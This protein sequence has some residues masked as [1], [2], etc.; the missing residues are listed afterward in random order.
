MGRAGQPVRASRRV[1]PRAMSI[2]VGTRDGGACRSPSAGATLA[3]SVRN[4]TG[5][6]PGA[7]AGASP[8]RASRGREPGSPTDPKASD[9]PHRSHDN[10]Q[11]CTSVSH[12][13]QRPGGARTRSARA[14]GP[15]RAPEHEPDGGIP[16][17]P[18]RVPPRQRRPYAGQQDQHDG[19]SIDYG[20]HASSGVIGPTAA[21]LPEVRRRPVMGARMEAPPRPRLVRRC[22]RRRV[23]NTPHA[24]SGP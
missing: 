1:D 23:C 18:R 12:E 22:T 24:S 5:A 11:P 15:V 4:A 9:A 10:A 16:R 2:G 20:L 7:D 21:M 3:P 13:G 17:A 8:G 14:I 19:D 6:G